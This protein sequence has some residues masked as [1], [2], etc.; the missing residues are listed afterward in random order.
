LPKDSAKEGDNLIEALRKAMGSDQWQG[1]RG[2]KIDT[3]FQPGLTRFFNS[4]NPPLPL[5]AHLIG[6][7]N[8][9]DLFEKIVAELEKYQDV[10]LDIVFKDGSGN[11]TSGHMLT[12]VGAVATKSG[13]LAL[14]VYDPKST[15]PSQNKK[16]LDIYEIIR[17]NK[18]NG[19]KGSNNYAAWIRSAH[20]VSATIPHVIYWMPGT[21]DFKYSVG[22][23]CPQKIGTLEIASMTEE[24]RKWKIS[25]NVSWLDVSETSGMTPASV[26]VS[27]N[28]STTAPGELTGNIDIA[29]VDPA[30][31]ETLP[32]SQGSVAVAGVIESQTACSDLPG[33]YTLTVESVTD[34]AEHSTYIGKPFAQPVSIAVAGTSITVTGQTPFVSVSGTLAEDCSFTATGKGTVA[35][36]PNVSIVMKGTYYSQT[37]KISA[38]YEMGADGELP[39]GKSIIYNVS[40][41]K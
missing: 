17:P 19:Y 21:M 37:G 14:E 40:G 2:V 31:G 28:C 41:H 3:D 1:G 18:I 30:T 33:A 20:A 13:K 22:S 38:T 5:E 32:G 39:Q 4:F 8:D 26:E 12:V 25:E 15:R 34:P 29:A 27:F 6:T 11:I 24:A 9:A 23:A 36:F 7:E 35:G 10:E 16:P